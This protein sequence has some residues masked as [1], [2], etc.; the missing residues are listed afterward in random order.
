VKAHYFSNYFLGVFNEGASGG[1]MKQITIPRRLLSLFIICTLAWMFQVTAV[2]L[3]AFDRDMPAADTGPGVFERQAP[4]ASVGRR[5]L[6]LP[7]VIGVVAAGAIA[8]VLILVVF[9]T[10]YDVTGT[11]DI[12]YRWSNSNDTHHFSI[13]FSGDTSSGT[14]TINDAGDILTGTYTQDKKNVSWIHNVETHPVYAGTFSDKNTMAGTMTAGNAT[15][16][17][18]GTRTASA[19]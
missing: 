18:T 19:Q 10:S 5:S 15:G 14:C 1:K 12:A 13:T 8:A 11:W 4:A 2:P 7:I 16:T 17:W 3:Q 6:L 9:K